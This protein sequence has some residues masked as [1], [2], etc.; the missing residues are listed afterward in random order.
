MKKFIAVLLAIVLVFGL[1]AC[2]GN[3]ANTSNGANA[4]TANTGNDTPS[5]DAPTLALDF[6]YALTEDTPTGQATIKFKE[7]CETLSNGKITVNLYPSSQLGSER[8]MQEACSM[9]TLDICIGSTGTLVNFDKRFMIYDM[10]LACDDYENAYHSA[11][12]EFGQMMM[13]NLAEVNL[14]GLGYVDPGFTEILNAKH[15][16]V[17]PED[18]AGMNI[19][20][21]ETVGYLTTLRAL[22]A[23]PVQSA[24][25][26]VYNLVQ[27]GAVDG[28][29]PPI[30]QVWMFSLHEIAHYFSR[31][32][33]FYS[34]VI[35]TMSLDLWNELSPEYQDIIVQASEAAVKESRST[36]ERMED[37][38]V[39][40][41]EKGGMIVRDYTDEERQAWIDYVQ[42]NVYPEIIPSMIPQ[43]LWD[44]YV[45]SLKL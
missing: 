22:K 38:W 1:A 13:D 21:M 41:M 2:G 36:R 27:N 28:C 39:S 30:A 33:C 7:V 43:D 24:T 3:A 8:E 17:T 45:E 23:N 29:C 5:D 37:Y 10:P 9:N 12:G 18:I 32:H 25:S 26:E 11:D 31:I 20:C 14:K 19:R 42:E 40:E 4:N 44:A 35:I 16:L 34:P 15:E 6:G